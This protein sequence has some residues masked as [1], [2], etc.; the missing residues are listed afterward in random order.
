MKPSNNNTESYHY[1]LGVIEQQTT[2]N[3]ISIR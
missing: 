2:T 3:F 1:H